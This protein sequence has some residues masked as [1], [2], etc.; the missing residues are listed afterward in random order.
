M[1]ARLYC[2]LVRV[3][4]LLAVVAPACLPACAVVAGGAA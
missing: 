4:S 1:S 3:V 2:L